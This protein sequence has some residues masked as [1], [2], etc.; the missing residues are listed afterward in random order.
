[1]W[2]TLE[3]PQLRNS[4]ETALDTVAQVAKAEFW[5]T[6]KSGEHLEEVPFATMAGTTVTTGVIDLLFRQGE[7]WRLIDYKTDVALDGSGY[8]GQLTAYRKSL[9]LL[10][11]D[12]ADAELFQVRQTR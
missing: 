3:E 11:L 4:L 9:K 8:Q 1:M 7:R 2:L 6:A 12:L 5:R 10:N